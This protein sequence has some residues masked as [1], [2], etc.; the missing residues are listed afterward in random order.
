LIPSWNDWGQVNDIF[1]TFFTIVMIVGYLKDDER[2][3]DAD[4]RSGSINLTQL[5]SPIIVGALTMSTHK[6]A[7][8]AHKLALVQRLSPLPSVCQGKIHGMQCMFSS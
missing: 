5:D 7:C 6:S 2:S 8:A 3:F 1:N 4:M